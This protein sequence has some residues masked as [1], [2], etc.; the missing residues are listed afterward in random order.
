[1]VHFRPNILKA[2]NNNFITYM[3]NPHAYKELLKDKLR[4]D[5]NN[6]FRWH[7][8]GDIPNTGYWNMMCDIA[9]EM[10]DTKFVVFTKRYRIAQ[11][12]KKKPDNLSVLI[13]LWPKEDQSIQSFID[14]NWQAIRDIRNSKIAWLYGDPRIAS[15]GF[16]PFYCHGSCIHCK[17]CWSDKRDIVLSRH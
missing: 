10:E 11:M 4:K 9:S 6:Y 16:N 1:M 7:V 14:I 13:S 3:N 17:Q 8:G 5:G 2:W 12:F 15:E